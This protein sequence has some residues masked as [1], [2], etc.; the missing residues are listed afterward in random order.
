MAGLPLPCNTLSP[1]CQSFSPI[2]VTLK[3]CPCHTA[4]KTGAK[5]GLGITV[6]LCSLFT[7]YKSP[8]PPIPDQE[9]ISSFKV[10]T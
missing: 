5:A 6:Y 2:G 4:E 7:S 10:E 3:T 8:S 9:A 1:Q